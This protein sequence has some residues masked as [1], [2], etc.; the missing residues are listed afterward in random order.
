MVS[1][2][3]QKRELQGNCG[4]SNLELT[5]IR[6][7]TLLESRNTPLR[8]SWAWLTLKNT[9]KSLL[10]LFN[11]LTSPKS[12]LHLNW[13]IQLLLIWCARCLYATL[14]GN[15]TSLTYQMWLG[16]HKEITLSLSSTFSKVSDFIYHV[17]NRYSQILEKTQWINWNYMTS[18]NTTSTELSNKKTKRKRSS[19]SSRNQILKRTCS[20]SLRLSWIRACI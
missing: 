16:K 11:R 19:R 2:S 7:S 12:V 10:F 4:S 15:S 9:K 8:R 18:T 6:F 1:K 14:Q 5:W 3:K 17:V 20:K 13:K